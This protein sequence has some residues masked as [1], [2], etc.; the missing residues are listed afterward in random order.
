MPWQTTNV[1]EKRIEFVIRASLAD[2]NLSA[3][4]REFK[5]SRPTGYKW[6][7]RYREANSVTELAEKSR[8]PH[9]SPNHTLPPMESLIIRLHKGNFGLSGKKIQV[10]L[11][12]MGH[13]ISPVTCHRVL[14]RNGFVKPRMRNNPATKQF[15]REKPNQLWQ[16]DFKGPFN[17]KTE[18]CLP[19]SILDD[20]SR[21]MVGL[22][23]LRS[24]KGKGVHSSLINCFEKH[25][26]PDAILTDHGTPWWSTTNGHG[27]TW[28]SVALLKQGI[29]LLWSGYRHPQT[30]GKVERFHRTLK[31]G[32]R[33]NGRP[34]LWSDWQ[35]L[36]EKYRC[37]YNEVR[38]HES[39]GMKTPSKRYAPSKLAYNPDPPQWEY[40][41]RAEVK[42]LNVQGCLSLNGRYYFVCEA[43]AHE[44]VQ[45]KRLDD[46]L[47]VK[48]R[49]M[50]IREINLETNQTVPIVRQA[51]Q[52]N[53]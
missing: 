31:D 44:W 13:E 7:G 29:K 22:Y 24:T 17:N 36:L 10:L 4:C 53:V 42:R 33:F 26:L 50:Y 1:M 5:I 37:N 21:Y 6:L 15:E 43:L 30:Q 45:L 8:R 25:G 38:P 49:N 48:F 40:P 35:P 52:T 12:R 46:K 23:A 14:K 28:L 27:L 19:L 2:V 47:L 34:T 16:M 20:H 51:H 32:I 3:L 9:R 41:E 11:K 39:L 18:P